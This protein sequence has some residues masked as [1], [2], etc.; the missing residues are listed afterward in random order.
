M[1]SRGKEVNCLI[2]EANFGKAP[3]NSIFLR[4]T[5]EEL[6][7]TTLGKNIEFNIPRRIY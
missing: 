1:I 3:N 2:L 6:L 4:V 5:N 7:T